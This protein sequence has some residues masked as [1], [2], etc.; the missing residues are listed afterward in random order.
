LANLEDAQPAAEE[1]VDVNE[2]ADSIVPPPLET[3]ADQQPPHL[4]AV[5]NPWRRRKRPEGAKV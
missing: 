5:T 2:S 1:G 4:A 3:D